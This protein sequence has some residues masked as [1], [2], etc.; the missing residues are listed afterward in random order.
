MSST[1][2]QDCQKGRVE[3]GRRN[4][5]QHSTSSKGMERMEAGRGSVMY[6][7][8]G[9]EVHL[10]SPLGLGP[11]PRISSDVEENDDGRGEV[12]LEKG[13]GDGASVRG[14]APDRPESDVEL[15]DEDEED[16]DNRK[17]GAPDSKDGLV[18]KL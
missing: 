16:E 2:S 8:S 4:A 10:S 18:G 12:G 7:S 11:L 14:H 13:V 1:V 17:P 5:S 9:I 6:L 3:K 15:G